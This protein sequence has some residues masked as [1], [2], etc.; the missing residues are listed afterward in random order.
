MRTRLRTGLAALG[1]GLALTA[2][3]AAPAGAAALTTPR[4]AWAHPE[5][6]VND[7]A[8]DAR[9]TGSGPY[10]KNVA[11]ITAVNA[12]PVIMNGIGSGY[13]TNGLYAA[14]DTTVPN[15]AA[16][17]AEPHSLVGATLRWTN[18]GV[19]HS[20]MFVSEYRRD[21][22]GNL[23]RVGGGVYHDGAAY[24]CKAGWTNGLDK[25]VTGTHLQAAFPNSCIGSSAYFVTTSLLAFNGSQTDY[26]TTPNAVF[27]SDDDVRVAGGTF[28][29]QITVRKVGDAVYMWGPSD[30]TQIKYTPS[31]KT[32]TL[33]QKFAGGGAALAPGTSSPFGW[34]IAD[35]T[36]GASPA[37][38][39]WAMSAKLGT[40]RKWH[41]SAVRRSTVNG[42]TADRTWPCAASAARF[43]YNPSAGTAVFTTP[44]SCF[45][46][47]TAVRAMANNAANSSGKVYS[48][49]VRLS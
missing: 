46:D 16:F 9:G 47:V 5:A 13:Q 40:D 48:P 25:S 45:G 6:Y 27:S 30:T 12:Y 49:L 42:V 29:R 4:G 3:A 44:V 28:L 15:L 24:T 23:T 31:S 39:T 21:T 36:S 32:L 37:H 10:G 17:K 20:A 35:S 34:D 19:Q 11:E 18:H 26:A 38:H 7:A 8:N 43:S 22:N 2:A 41:L 14:V 33:S 1:A